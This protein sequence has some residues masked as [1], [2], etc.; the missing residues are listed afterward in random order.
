MDIETT[1]RY[2][3]MD[4]KQSKIFLSRMQDVK[5]NKSIPLPFVKSTN[6]SNGCLAEIKKFNPFLMTLSAIFDLVI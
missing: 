4:Q 1:E 3:V 5:K 2:F 6:I